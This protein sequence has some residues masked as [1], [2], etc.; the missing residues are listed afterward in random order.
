M[1]NLILLLVLANVLYFMWGLYVEK[2][3]EPGVAVIEASDLGPPLP[4]AP[5]Q[6]AESVS[7]A[8]AVLGASES[9][10][11]AAVVGRSCVTIGPF[12]TEEDA[13]EA[14]SRYRAEG[15]RANLRKTSGEIFVGH[16]VQIRSIATRDAGN[17]TL[18]QLKSGGLT[19]AY[20]VPNDD[21]TFN[22]SLGLFG[23]VE[24]AEK[25]ELDARALG[26]AADITPRT[27]EGEQF[28][29]DIGLPPGKG[30]GAIVSQYGE[31]Q[32]RLRGEATCPASR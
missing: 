6:S 15:M 29:A 12:R 3:P 18:E 2:D 24:R 31:E 1:K 9:V 27:R 22:V 11:L 32:V 28:W 8:G 20:I 13:D 26:L 10:D 23:D 16:W 14:V 17:A 19:D 21:G 25:V 5:P 4:A 30:A 7:S